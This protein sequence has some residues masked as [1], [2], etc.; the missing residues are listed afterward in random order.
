MFDTGANAN[1]IDG[2]VA[3]MLVLQVIDQNPTVVKGV[4]DSKVNANFG[5]HTGREI[6][7]N[8]STWHVACN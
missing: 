1:I 3:E 2:H 8:Y 7:Q 4:G 6:S 5:T